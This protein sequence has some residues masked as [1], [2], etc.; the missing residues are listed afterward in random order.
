METFPLTSQYRNHDQYYNPVGAAREAR[1][2]RPDQGPDHNIVTSELSKPQFASYNE[3]KTVADHDIRG[4]SSYMRLGVP[5]ACCYSWV[6]SRKSL[7]TS[8]FQEGLIVKYKSSIT[9][10]KLA[11]NFRITVTCH[12]ISCGKTFSTSYSCFHIDSRL[13]ILFCS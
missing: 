9:I 11:T 13:V 12:N 8:K 6:T 1:L 10:W 5:E 2:Q 4:R 3:L 7:G